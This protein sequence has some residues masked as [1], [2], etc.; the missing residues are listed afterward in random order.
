[1]VA[2]TAHLREHLVQP[3]E[4]SMEVHLNP[5]RCRRHILSVIL[6]AP[7]FDKGHSDGAHFS[8]LIHSLE[9][10]VHALGQQSGKLLVIE[11]F[12]TTARRYFADCG[13][14]KCVVVVAV[15]RLHKDRGIGQAF[16]VHLTAHVVQVH[17]LAYMSSCVLDGG[18]SID[19]GQL[20]ETEA[21]VVFVGRIGEAVND[22]GV[23]VGVV[24]LS[25]STVQLVV[26]DAGPVRW[27][28]VWNRF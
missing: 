16:R 13:W 14:V 24:H 25:H 1:M 3:L 5:A 27:L 8:Q 12:E 15:A 19:I 4:R 7:S 20:T 10:V 17:S 2:G 21:V 18:V 9:A 11:N 6:S 23:S 26:G 22:D 28:L